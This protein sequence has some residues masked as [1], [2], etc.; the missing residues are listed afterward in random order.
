MGALCSG[1]TELIRVQRHGGAGWRAAVAEMQGWRPEHE[2]AHF[3]KGGSGPSQYHVFGVLD[4]HGGS[5]AARKAAVRLAE[6][7]SQATSSPNGDLDQSIEDAFVKT[8][9][10]LRDELGGGPDTSGSTVVCGALRPTESGA[11]EAIIANAGDSRGLFVWRNPSVRHEASVDHKPNRADEKAR[12]YKAEGFVTDDEVGSELV[13]RLDGVLAVSRGIGDFCYKKATDRPPS[14]QKVSCIPEL[15]KGE[16]QAGD[17]LILACDG[18][19]DVLSNDE[20]VEVV[21]AEMEAQGSENLGEVCAQILRKCFEKESKDNMT[22]MLIQVGV[23]GTAF[24]SAEKDEVMDLHK[25]TDNPDES[26]RQSYRAFLEYCAESGKLP[27]EAQAILDEAADE[28]D[29]FARRRRRS[30]GGADNDPF[31]EAA[32]REKSEYNMDDFDDPCSPKLVNKRPSEKGRN[33]RAFVAAADPKR[34]PFG[35]DGEEVDG[36]STQADTGAG[37]DW[38][39]YD[40]RVTL[41][42]SD[43]RQKA[44]DAASASS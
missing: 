12:I 36:P 1:P 9:V 22:F 4:G 24:A 15:Y 44:I 30:L 41:L 3:M 34:F 32:A 13:P 5:T 31:G 42:S 11:F 16:L 35:D 26:V 6:N 19:F 17:L 29:D 2:D 38:D 23:D 10:W 21:L 39:E 25:F 28:A 37:D 43:E 27:P 14:E 20:L 18:I 7:L 33:Y 40:R 8:D